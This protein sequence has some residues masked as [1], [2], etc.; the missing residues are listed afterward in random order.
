MERLEEVKTFQWRG[1]IIYV[2]N[3]KRLAIA[4]EEL[5]NLNKLRNTTSISLTVIV[6]LPVLITPIALCGCETWTCQE[7]SKGI[8]NAVLQMAD[9]NYWDTPN[10]QQ[11]CET[12][13]KRP[14]WRQWAASGSCTSKETSTVWPCHLNAL[15]ACTWWCDACLSEW[16]KRAKKGKMKLAHWHCKRWKC[17]KGGTTMQNLLILWAS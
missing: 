6:D 17:Q 13:D 9:G 12:G 15:F 3:N 7:A 2:E 8:R 16:C 1:G 14:D 4:T 11:F 5:T 10:Y